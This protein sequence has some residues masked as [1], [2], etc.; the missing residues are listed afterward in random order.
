LQRIVSIVGEAEISLEDRILYY[1]A[2]K[3]LN[4]M[5]Q[6][7]FV[8]EEQTGIPGKYIKREKTISDVNE[9]LSGKMDNVSEDKLL[10]IG[11]LSEVKK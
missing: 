1:R 4:Y 2:K 8:L 7:L 3:L 6:D 10:Y 5:T 9:I 11:D